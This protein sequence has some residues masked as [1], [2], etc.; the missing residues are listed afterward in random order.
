L[1]NTMTDIRAANQIFNFVFLPQYFLAGLISPINVLPWY[2]AVLSLLSP[3]RYVIDLARGVV[4][5][6]SPE[7]RRVVLDRSR[8]CTADQNYRRPTKVLRPI[9][10][11]SPSSRTRFIRTKLAV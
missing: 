10:W 1:L 3:M 9:P 7:Y 6:G 8:W 4:F 11:K 5:A 2:L